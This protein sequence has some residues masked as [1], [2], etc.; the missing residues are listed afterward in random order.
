[1]ASKGLPRNADEKFLRIR[2]LAHSGDKVNIKLPIDF[3]KQMI[4]NNALEFF[5][6]NESLIDGKKI[7][8]VILSAF[9]YD[10][11]GEIVTFERRNKD[12]I[13]IFIG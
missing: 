8:D 2:V 9:D 3:S 1:M 10:L 4:Q 13:K 11:T 12:V 5:E 7:T 6:E